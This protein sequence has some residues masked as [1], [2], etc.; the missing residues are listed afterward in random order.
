EEYLAWCAGSDVFA[1]DARPRPLAPLTL[2]LRRVQIHAAVTALVNAGTKPS[3]I[4]SLAD[5]VAPDAFKTILR[6][7]YQAANGRDNAFNRDLAEALVQIAREWVKIAA[8]TLPELKRLLRKMPI[9]QSGL[10]DKNK[11]FLR[12]FDDSAAL[13]RV[14]D[15]PGQLWTEVR[16]E[17]HP[18]FRT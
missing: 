6:Q 8:A 15:L 7:R 9:P 4:E 13:H 10:T 17:A 5:L 3:E 2:R 16:R 11:R 1:A 14:R 12:Q 18:N